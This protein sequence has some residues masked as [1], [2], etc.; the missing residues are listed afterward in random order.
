M[1]EV[2]ALAVAGAVLL[3]NKAVWKAPPHERTRVVFDYGG[4]PGDTT[5]MNTEEDYWWHNYLDQ[6]QWDAREARL[7]PTLW[8][9]PRGQHLH[10]VTNRAY[11][12]PKYFM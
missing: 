4:G 11:V 8:S 3:G 2:L 1:A 9:R 10:N 12:S 5:E 7:E 6:S